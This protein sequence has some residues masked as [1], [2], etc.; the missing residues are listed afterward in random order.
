MSEIKLMQGDCLERMSE[1]PDGSIDAIIAD[2]PYNLVGKI[3]E[4]HLF[5]QCE[6]R[7]TD[8]H[9]ADSM[10]FDVGFDQ[11]AWIKVAAKKLKKGGHIIIFNDWE[12]MGDVAK[13]LRENKIKV[14]TLNHWQKTNPLPAEWRRRFVPGREYFIHGLKNG[15][16]TF[17]TDSVHHG[18][19]IMGLTPKGEKSY[20]S[21]P[22]QKP[23]ALLGEIIEIITDAGDVILD[24]FM[25]SGTTGVA[26]KRLNRDFIGIELDAGYFN[27]ALDRIE[28]AK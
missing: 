5:R 3:G 6:V 12:N 24:P 19:F 9:N 27:N 16:Y 23:V 1:I 26:A 15:K 25:G 21:H 18:D 2:P 14:K 4:L 13:Y 28:S 17:N 20:G 8:T 7:G 11:S 22:N 10:D